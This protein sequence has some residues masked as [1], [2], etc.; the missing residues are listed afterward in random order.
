MSKKLYF[1]LIVSCSF[2]SFSQNIIK[3]S[4][5]NKID[6]SAIAIGIILKSDK[7]NTAAYTFS[8]VSGKYTIETNKTGTFILTANAM[9]FASKSVEVILNGSD[10]TKIINFELEEKITELNEVIIQNERAITVKKDTI[11]FLAKAFLQGN[12]Q[13]VE[14]LLKKI[15]GLN[16]EAD[17]T[18]KVG[19]REVE[20]V[21]IDGDDMFERGYKIL[22]KNMPVAPVEKVE[23][24]QHYSNNKHLKDIENS[25]KVALNLTLKDDFKRQWFGNATLGYG[26]ISENF[27]DT[28]ADLM[29]FGKKSKFYFLT[30]LNNIGSDATGDINNLIRP[31]R[32]DEPG[33]IGDNQ[34]ANTILGLGGDQPNLKQK[35]VNFNNAELLSLNSIFTISSKLKLKALV[36][37]NS[38]EQDFFRNSLQS[39]TLGNTD[40]TNTEDYIGR[41]RTATGFGK[42]DL[43]YDVS[44][45]KTI[46]FTSKFNK[47]NTRNNSNLLFNNDLFNEK[48]QSNNELID[49]KIIFTN[50]FQPTKVFL[51]SARYINEKT[52][53]QY[54]VNQFILN[55]LFT[56]NANNTIQKSTNS[57][58][59]AGVEAHMLNKKNNGN[60]FELKLGNQFRTDN[61][62]TAFEL[63]NNDNLL[64]TPLDYQNNLRYSTND[65]YASAQYRLK[66]NKI[67][68]SS[69][70]DAHQLF[71]T[72]Q[73]ENTAT[74]QNP[75]F[76]VPKVGFDWKINTKNKIITSY[77]F[78]TTNAG[79]LD[80]YSSFV[81]TS[82]RSFSKGLEGFNQ[83]ESSAALL[84]Y[85]FGNWGDKFFASTNLIYTTNND[86]FSTN[87]IIAQNFSIT[88]KIIIRDRSF[89]LFASNLDRYFKTIKS[90]LKIKLSG[91]QA[92]FKNIV[93]NSD[94]REVK[95]LNATY[96]AELRSGFS[97]IFNYHIGSTYSF[98]EITTTT[99]NSFTD[100]MSFLDLSFVFNEKINF[101]LQAERYYFGNLDNANNKYYFLDLETRWTAT[102]NK[103]TFFL[104]GNNLFNTTTFRNFNI[105]DISTSQSEYRLLPRYVMLKMEFRF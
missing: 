58:Q 75:F 76:V 67:A 60:L 92:N 86:F 84:N 54:S 79:I 74:T 69:A 97:G 47:T 61:L 53:Q 101:Q 32:F 64:S 19:N 81:Q 85:T 68:L 89:L 27:Y 78:N 45:T 56:K 6:K 1:F 17:G 24:L 90:N 35:R 49:N 4:V 40:F 39:F 31:F 8:D 52:P 104:S 13:V 59:F 99:K 70:V 11:I 51:L 41:T 36:F 44:K 100:N 105:S 23:L 80:V 73:T 103:L 2:I 12:E 83:L 63:R 22:T 29:N 57:M 25:E 48:L 21:M 34:S 18:I 10:Q 30:N 82:F 37:L 62:F 42:L 46:E 55:D 28:K 9:G 91:S 77:S 15:P 38:D 93:N 72:L 33:S 95:Q 16:I 7:G 26:A 3:G 102:K 65:L 98:N 14:D 96:G 66:I 71:N 43:I 94:L 88:E 20:K 50:K 87:S 5:Q